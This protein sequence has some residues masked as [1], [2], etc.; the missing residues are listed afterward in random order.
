MAPSKDYWIRRAEELEQRAAEQGETLIRQALRHYK[1]A[2][3]EISSQI[4]EFYGRYASEQGLSYAEA[5]KVLRG[6]EAKAW[7]KTLGA[8][9]DEIGALPDGALKNRLKAELDARAYSSRITRLDALK[10]QVDMEADRLMIE[11][12][13]GMGEGFGDLYTDSYYRKMYDIQRHAGKM[14]DF[15]H[16]SRELVEQAL[17]YPWSG[18]DFSSRLWENKR[19]LL[20]H[21]REIMTQGAIQGKGIAA[22]SK[23]LSDKLGQ[24]YKT[25]ERLI[26][27]E[28][29]HFHNAADV[30]AYE[31]A[32][33]RQYEFIAT[34]DNRTSAVCAGLD[35]KV[36][37]IEDAQTGVNYPPMHPNCRST[38]V[39]YDPDEWKDW[40]A[41]GQP[42][43]ERMTYAQWAAEQGIET[44]GVLK[45]NTENGRIKLKMEFTPANSAREAKEY[46]LS[47]LHLD[48]VDY[49]R[50]DL[51]VA[52]SVNREITAYYDV[53]GDL[54][55]QGVLRSVMYYPKEQNFYAAYQPSSGIVYMREVREKDSLEKMLKTAQENFA[56]G[57][58]STAQ[59][60]HAIRH[61]L[62]HAVQMLFTKNN[63]AKQ[64]QIAALRNELEKACGIT[65]W[66]LND[67][68]E[69]MKKAGQYLSYYALRDDW[70]FIAE[71][72][73]EYMG[74]SPRETARKVVDILLR[75]D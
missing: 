34:L 46:A 12:E 16:L 55:E 33:V 39:E 69:N 44:P 7:T 58:W 56:A 45:D 72:V 17:S 19:A 59:T 18:A 64:K 40:E 54:H 50:F 73:A 74:G 51:D 43:P 4:E 8:Y 38:T 22:L 5:V 60:E 57:F 3:Q 62:G 53:F 61:E 41:I 47:V 11:L 6:S 9:M 15:A 31:A 24:S 66:S 75:K 26:R 48:N 42:M 37:D 25:A 35:G 1:R 14:F 20:F 13:D 70:E 36:F 65:Q 28:A 2:A 52:N 23:E 21:L 32:G 49:D 68:A 30:A 27:T 63:A 29:N 71:A 10:A 67:S